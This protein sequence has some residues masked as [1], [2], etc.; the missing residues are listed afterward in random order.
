[1][2]KPIA[3]TP[4]LQGKEAV[5]FLNTLHKEADKPVG[6]TPTPKLKQAQELIEKHGE[7]R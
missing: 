7:N 3:P 5:K 6:L 2:A 1:M 4:V